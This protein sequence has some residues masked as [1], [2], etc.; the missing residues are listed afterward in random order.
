MEATAALDWGRASVMLCCLALAARSDYSTLK[1]KDQLWL[2][3]TAP[4]IALLVL[5]MAIIEGSLLNFYMSAALLTTASLS[6]LGP[7]DL[8]KSLGWSRNEFAL[9][10]VYVIGLTGLIGGAV[11]SMDTNFVDLVL[12]DESPETTLWWGLLGA[13]LTMVLY[14]SAW[15]LGLIQ[16]GA[17]VKGLILV[18]L[19]FPTWAFLPEPPFSPEESVFSIPPSM[20]MFLWAGTA[21]LIAPPVLFLQNVARGS[22]SSFSDIKMAW[23][24]T[25]MPISDMGDGPSWLLT[26]VIEHEGGSRVINRILPSGSSPNT[27]D[28]SE[29]LEK[30]E[31]MGIES[32]WVAS[33]H[34]FLVYLFLAMVPL[35]IFGDPIAFAMAIL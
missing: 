32:V 20:A 18:T 14:L 35:L 11:H 16:G 30:L 17:D 13:I 8:R 7:P 19:A 28:S 4:V 33:K 9:A 22:L 1:V 34:P 12:G 24:A 31:S 29:I 21:F 5:E 6:I 23:H 15:K 27:E 26:D 25:K 2:T 10:T 3:W